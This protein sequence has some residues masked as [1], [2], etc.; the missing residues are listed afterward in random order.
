MIN[1]R[2]TN[3]SDCESVAGRGKCLMFT[4]SLPLTTG[5]IRKSKLPNLCTCASSKG[6]G[7]AVHH[8]W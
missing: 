1:W 5:V 4:S 8:S 3:L 2:F 7:A 6:G